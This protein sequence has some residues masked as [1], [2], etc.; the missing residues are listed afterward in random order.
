MV[1]LVLVRVSGLCLSFSIY[2]LFPQTIPTNN[3]QL[4]DTKQLI[5]FWSFTLIHFRHIIFISENV[6]I[7]TVTITLHLDSLSRQPL[8]NLCRMES[9]FNNIIIVTDPTHRHKLVKS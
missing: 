3:S 9:C 1:S 4:F 6:T 2:Y 8:L 7:S 5:N